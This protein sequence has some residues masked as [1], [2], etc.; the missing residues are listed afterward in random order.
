MKRHNYQNLQSRLSIK[1]NELAE[2]LFASLYL[3]QIKNLIVWLHLSNGNSTPWENRYSYPLN[4]RDKKKAV[5][6]TLD[7]FLS[8][9]ISHELPNTTHSITYRW[10][11][12]KHQVGVGFFGVNI[13]ISTCCLARIS[14]CCLASNEKTLENSLPQD[15]LHFKHRSSK[16]SLSFSFT[17]KTTRA[18]VKHIQLIGQHTTVYT[19]PRQTTSREYNADVQKP[20]VVHHQT[21]SVW[22][23]K[24]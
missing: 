4:Q 19:Y 5:F 7:A 23:N 22:H 24:A 3:K 12:P 6:Q 10:S 16:A 8:I 21:S 2:Q 9:Q 11:A 13:R 1:S 15:P 20:H 17:L 14:T 18:N